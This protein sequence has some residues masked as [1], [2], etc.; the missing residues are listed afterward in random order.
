M[1]H[2]WW[3]SIRS[4]FGISQEHWGDRYTAHEV[5]PSAHTHLLACL[6]HLQGLVQQNLAGLC[7]VNHLDDSIC[8]R[9]PPPR[10]ILLHADAS[11]EGK[12]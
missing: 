8:Q 11:P 2:L 3:Q 4:F 6:H 12:L 5:N 1:S 9:K 10:G 7:V